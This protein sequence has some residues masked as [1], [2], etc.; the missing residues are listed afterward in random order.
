MNVHTRVPDVNFRLP[1]GRRI[2]PADFEGQK[3]ALF[4]RAEGDSASF[5]R[6]VR[7]YAALAAEFEQAGTWVLGV[8]RENDL[9]NASDTSD[10]IRTAL[11]PDG[12]GIDALRRCLGGDLPDAGEAATFLIDRD[13]TV[14]GAWASGGHA[15]DALEVARQHP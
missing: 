13:G 9:E 11:D 8:T 12:S 4:Y 5:R 1:G 10:T 2:S 15:R 6:E 14:R 7:D 3:L